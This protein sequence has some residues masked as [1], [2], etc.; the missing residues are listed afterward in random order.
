MIG[1]SLCAYASTR[2][3]DTA[4]GAVSAIVG[5]FVLMGGLEYVFWSAL[6]RNGPGD[7]SRVL[8]L[9]QRTGVAN[10]EAAR[11]G[12]PIASAILA[13][14]AQWWGLRLALR[15]FE[16]RLGN[17]A[18]LSL[19]RRAAAAGVLAI[20]GGAAY[21]AGGYDDAIPGSGWVPGCVGALSLIVTAAIV[22]RFPLAPFSVPFAVTGKQLVGAWLALAL[23][24][25]GVHFWWKDGVNWGEHGAQRSIASQSLL[26]GLRDAKDVGTVEKLAVRVSAELAARRDDEAVDLLRSLGLAWSR[27]EMPDRPSLASNALA[28]SGRSNARSL[29]SSRYR[30]SSDWAISTPPPRAHATSRASTVEHDRN[31]GLSMLAL[32]EERRGNWAEALAAAEQ[33]APERA[34][35]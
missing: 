35:P 17:G 12:L 6:Q 23:I 29:F 30:H 22:T 4:R 27:V 24:A 9:I 19:A 18:P 25:A 2:K 34:F 8:Q 26:D 11:A 20:A 15:H 3:V 32:V 28:V 14:V 13:L 21:L 31:Y 5:A 10:F 33:W 1:L 7:P 16:T